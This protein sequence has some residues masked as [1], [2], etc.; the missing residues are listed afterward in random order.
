MS[1]EHAV[2]RTNLLPG[3]LAALRYNL[4][5]QARRVRLFEIGQ[6]FAPKAGGGGAAK[7][8]RTR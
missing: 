5:R 3:L 6:C 7:P 4:A 1:S 2:M 8:P